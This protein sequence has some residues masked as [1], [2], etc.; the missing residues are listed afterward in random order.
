MDEFCLVV[1]FYQ[2]GPA[3]NKATLSRSTVTWLFQ[4]ETDPDYCEVVR[5]V[6]P[7]NQGRR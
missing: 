6:H 5:D 2:K 4:W 3:N 7:Y 1:K